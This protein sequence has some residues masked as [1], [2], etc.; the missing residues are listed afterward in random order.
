MTSALRVQRLAKR[1]GGIAAISDLSFDIDEHCITGLIGPNGAGKTT[2]FNLITG[3][4][5]PD[6]G[7]VTF[8]G[9]DITGLPPQRLAYLGLAR[10]FQ[11]IRLFGQLTVRDNVALAVPHQAG[12]RLVPALLAPR[13]VRREE[14][15]VRERSMELLRFVGMADKSDALADDLSYGQQKLVLIARLLALD[16]KLMLL[17]EPCSGLDPAMLQ[18]VTDLLRELVAQ[19][20]TVLLIE[21]NMDV[22]REVAENVVFLSEG[23]AQASGRTADILADAVLTQVYF[24]M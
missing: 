15:Q 8:A 3:F 7:T 17:D 23:R 14:R 22:V 20:R 9:R 24:G 12:E 13:R 1:F 21:H 19:G 16:P 4:L 5:R 18:R 10:S 2:I 6:A 11:D